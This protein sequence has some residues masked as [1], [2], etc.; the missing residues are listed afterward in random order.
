MFN[1][2]LS[3]AYNKKVLAGW[4]LLLTTAIGALGDKVYVQRTEEITALEGKVDNL[5]DDM[6]EVKRLL[7]ENS[8][9][10]DRVLVDTEVLKAD[11][12]SHKENTR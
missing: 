8:G 12:R 10:L 7:R 2:I 9:K 6:A 11:L 1:G 5:T 3:V 4:C